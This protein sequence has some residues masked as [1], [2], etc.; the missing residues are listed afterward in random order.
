MPVV[1]I[2]AV[3]VSIVALFLRGF[4][5]KDFKEQLSSENL[6]TP[7]VK[8]WLVQSQPF[9]EKMQAYKAGVI[10]K[11]SGL[12]IYVIERNEQW[13]WV[14]GAYMTRDEA[15]SVIQSHEILANATS[16]LFEIETKQIK[17]SADAITICNSLFDAINAVIDI[18]LHLRTNFINDIQDADLLINLTDKYNIIKNKTEDLQKLNAT[19]KNQLIASIVYTANVNILGLQDV[20]FGNNQITLSTINTALLNAIFSLDNF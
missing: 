1:L 13:Y 14:A 11:K 5:F 2:V 4:K 7:S 17:I 16:E 8:V 18:L 12:G 9:P 10:G 19:L 3:I 15:D 20:I 6:E